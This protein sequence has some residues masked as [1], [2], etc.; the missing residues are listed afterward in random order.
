M[1]PARPFPFRGR[2]GRKTPHPL[3]CL[4]AIA[5]LLLAVLLPAG[6]PVRAQVPIE[7][8]A[9]LSFLLGASQRTVSSNT[10]RMALRGERTQARVRL[11]RPDALGGSVTLPDTLAQCAG[12]ISQSASTAP[13]RPE[14]IVTLSPAAN[15][16][17]GDILYI[18]IEDEDQNHDPDL[19]EEVELVVE[20]GGGDAEILALTETA[21][22]S[23]VFTGGIVTRDGTAAVEENCVL[24]LTSGTSIDIRYTDREDSSDTVTLNLLVDPF[25]FVFDSVTGEPLDG[26][27]V[28]LVDAATGAPAQVFGN[29]GFSSYP[30][31]VTT[32]E[33]VTD[34]S[35]RVYS[36]AAGAYR[37][38][39][40]VPGEYRLLVEPL[41]NYAHPSTAPAE[42]IASLTAPNGNSFV[43]LTDGSYGLPFRVT[44]P[45]PLR[46]DIPLDP[47]GR[48]LLLQKTA[49]VR[50]AEAGDFVHYRVEARNVGENIVSG[51]ALLDAFPAGFRLVQGSL[52]IA[53]QKAEAAIGP[54]GDS[55]TVTLG[56]VAPG[57][58]LRVTYLLQV[59]ASAS[60]GTAL[61]R[62]E[63]FL[64]GESISNSAAA[65][66]RIRPPFFSDSATVIGRVS[67]GECAVDD[68]TRSG[69]PGVRL[70]MEDGR[71]VVTDEDGFYHFEGIDPGTHV[72]QVDMGTLP[73][74]Y[75]LRQCHANSRRAGRN[76][77]TFV[78]LQGGSL[79]REN[80]VLAA[81]DD[82]AHT[83][84]A[85]FV[86]D[87]AL[88]PRLD[89]IAAAGGDSDWLEGQQAGTEILFPVEG[90][91]PRAPAQRLVVKHL[92]GQ[93]VEATVNGE[94]ANPHSF[95]GK[96][97]GK[98]RGFAVSTWRA[99][100]LRE[101][102][103]RLE[104]LIRDR[105][106][107]LLE[108]LVREIWFV[109]DPA[110][111]ALVTEAS[112]LIADG[113][114]RPRIALR[115]TD[116]GGR[117]VRSG[118]TGSITLNAPYVPA[119]EID[120]QQER[121]LAGLERFNPTW[122]VRG[123]DGI[124]YIEL[125][126]TTVTGTVRVGVNFQSEEAAYVQEIE[127]WLEPGD[128]EF[129]LVGY[130]AGTHGHNA[131]TNKAERTRE[132]LLD[133]N[134][135][136]D[137]EVKLYAKGRIL[138]KWLMTLAIDS[139]RKDR[140]PGERR[141]LLGTID[142]DRFYTVYGD[143]S[144]QRFDAPSSDRLYLR[145]ERAQF[146]ALYGD[147][148]T[149]LN[150]TELTRYNRT[151]TGAKVEYRGDVFAFTGFAADT[152]LGFGRDEI[153]GNGLSGP[154]R[155]S[156][157][158]I[159]ANSDKIVIEVRDRF[160]SNIVISREAQTRHIDYDI[161]YL[162]GTV[163]FRE[164]ILSRDSS[165]NPIFVVADYETEGLAEQHFNAGGRVS[166]RFLNDKVEIGASYIRDSDNNSDTDLYG[167]DL[168]LKL[169][170]DTEIR[171]EYA[172]SDAD[173]GTLGAA[174]GEAWLVEAEHHSERLDI[175][176]YVREREAGFGVGQ[177]NAAE[178][179]TR[180]YGIDARVR[181][182]ENLSA[183]A[184]LYREEFLI[185]PARRNQARLEAEWRRNQTA[186]RAGVRI[187][188]D[189]GRD[190]L[191]RRSQLA[192]FGASHEFFGGKFALDANAEIALGG[193]D[194]GTSVDFPSRYRLD[195]RYRISDSVR[196]IAGHEIADGEAFD[197][198]NTNIGFDLAPWGGAQLAAT[199]NQ[200]GIT[201][202]G[203]RTFAAL[204]LKQ[205][206]PVGKKWTLDATFDGNRTIAGDFDEGGVLNPLHPAAS[207]GFLG[208][209]GLT[210]DF[211]AGT[212]GATYRTHDWSWTGRLE[213]RDG[214]GDRYGI[215]TAALR[216][217]R[218]GVALAGQASLFRTKTAASPSALSAN[219]RV[220]G[221]WRPIGS[222]FAALD[223]L[224]FD[225]QRVGSGPLPG[226]FSAATGFG[227]EGGRS[228]RIV[229]NLALN[230]MGAPW[231][232]KA[233][234][235]NEA[236]AQVSLYWGS[237][238]VADRYAGEEYDGFANMIGVEARY[239]ASPNIDLGI[240]ASVRHV[241]ES[242]TVDYAIGPSLGVSPA[243][244]AWLTVGYNVRGFHDRDFSRERYTR[245]GAYVTFRL[246]LDQLSPEALFR[247]SER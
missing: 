198:T 102:R 229:N 108:R 218:A 107:N 82:A 118:V 110:H 27:G 1:R 127:A 85:D 116:A 140:R 130:A 3:A 226:P 2:G 241:A 84:A 216:Q 182:E 178:G 174:K 75:E 185:G 93:F 12:Q 136:T 170:T 219:V 96:L 233:G 41:P 101:G 31:S 72:L 165:L 158:D 227:A 148:N 236:R 48:E 87:D 103:N 97:G 43:I 154:Y 132:A 160:R 220:S 104:A 128:Q 21:S 238:Y 32:G 152:A 239:D 169:R 80:F 222:K 129:V 9:E 59:G 112:R 47:A 60:E 74:G 247:R 86:A 71:Y 119:A 123:D 14:G 195:A 193:D 79:W 94:P 76:F 197:A 6:S 42:Q 134:P 206:V 24:L 145:L 23:G 177:L 156:S 28:T 162:S 77:S 16:V 46:V 18:L 184:S 126:P 151:L 38:P 214:E 183:T 166:S 223:R 51:A 141:R 111:A 180:K 221:A 95:E 11:L 245:S 39:F 147:Y 217:T 89:D 106:G 230:W 212:I 190:G 181:L 91:N 30:S 163:R 159:V 65:G 199:L 34:A 228:T 211:W 122:T 196:L 109:N 204:G 92:P 208:G 37:F 167:A 55:M 173:G 232:G 90:H 115:I 13:Q 186:A 133:D 231:T 64:G 124:A 98:K 35:G 155:L 150:R 25:G 142:P 161:D 207:G 33:T 120:A 225:L 171:A 215:T 81:R 44:G 242:G 22:D 29:D 144:Q 172:R 4:L 40:V 146:Y 52:R 246:K 138:G 49:S 36:P 202:A 10:V 143:G 168:R 20:T 78:E 203:P 187:V 63:A 200:Q 189:V 210:E 244:N 191:D 100:P 117:P 105:E 135:V 164:P 192:T 153:Q 224:E 213:Y 54:G 176:A 19:R 45:Q 7:N 73:R 125:E 66:V 175:A 243:T 179:G 131:L 83:G 69:V 139:D 114:Q 137:G 121:Q 205:S 67:A 201:E 209:P 58:T 237:K 240:A 50:E 57:E 99:L 56:A 26:V 17:P 149:G 188:D 70:M 61:N 5:A 194:A 235:V 234:E 88:P 8:T 68:D 62:V 53:G 15:I 113:R 157:R